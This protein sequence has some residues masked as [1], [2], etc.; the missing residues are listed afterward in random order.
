MSYLH[1]VIFCITVK[2]IS[3]KINSLRTAFA[4]E[5][6]KQN[7]RKSGAG[8]DDIYVSK[9]RHFNRLYF[10]RDTVRPGE[11]ECN[12]PEMMLSGSSH[13]LADRAESPEATCSSKAS[14]D[15]ATNPSNASNN[16]QPGPST[17]NWNKSPSALKYP[18]KNVKRSRGD[19]EATKMNLLNEAVRAIKNT[20]VVDDSCAVFSK[21]V[22]EK[23]RKVDPN[24]RDTVEIEILRL[25]SHYSTPPTPHTSHASY[26]ATPAPQFV[27]TGSMLDYL[28]S[29][30]DEV[31]WNN[32]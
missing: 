32:M 1:G 26:S 15:E 10:L 22:A 17:S 25:I 30:N 21:L 19:M 20:D 12:L 28:Y 6:R 27:E 3:T 8:A 18:K 9:W 14:S 4:S 2:E 13:S 11:S 29:S 23:M 5:V 7:I 31:S 24:V 16:I